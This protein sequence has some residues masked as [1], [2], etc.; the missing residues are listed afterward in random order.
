MPIKN[1]TTEVP[2]NRTIN[3]ISA[4]LG[5]AGANMV[6]TQFGEGGEPSGIAFRVFIQDVQL[7]FRLPVSDEGVSA[8]LMDK[9]L[10][11][12]P[13]QAKR[14]AWRI[15]KDWIDSQMVLIE[16]QQAELAQV[17]LPYA[18][19]DHGHTLYEQMTIKHFPQLT[20]EL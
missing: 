3:E 13:E 19:N 18:L 9:G 4:I 11:V 2:V 16:S 20:H 10:R 12:K 6:M 15:V 17:F 7:S 8:A 1:Y 14:I 5:R